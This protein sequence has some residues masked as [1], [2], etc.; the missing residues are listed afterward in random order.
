MIPETL[1][2]LAVPIDSIRPYPKNPRNGDIE[3]IKDS[4]RVNSQYRP[5][6]VNR[7]DHTILAGNHTYFA[8]IELGWQEI[9]ATFVDADEAQAARIVLVDNRTNDLARND[10]ALIAALLQELPS[11]EG[12]GY[13]DEALRDILKATTEPLSPEDFKEYGENIETDHECPRCGY[14]WS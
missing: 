7:R 13:D 3:P 6:V 12:T 5:I 1:K 11:T 10:D 9:A 4:L 2:Q 14:T 8:A